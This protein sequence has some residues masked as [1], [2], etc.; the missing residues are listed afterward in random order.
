[1]LFQPTESLELVGILT[2]QG[3]NK[4]IRVLLKLLEIEPKP[5]A[6]PSVVYIIVPVLLGVESFK[7]KFSD[8][9]PPKCEK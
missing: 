7:I 5:G 4:S 6:V 9:V 8:I 2:V 3:A 1:M